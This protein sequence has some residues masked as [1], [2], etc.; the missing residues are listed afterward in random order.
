MAKDC[1][2][3]YLSSPLEGRGFESLNPTRQMSKPC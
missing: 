1:D 3:I 2:L